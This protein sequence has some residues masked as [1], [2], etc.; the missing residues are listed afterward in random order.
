VQGIDAGLTFPRAG[1]SPGLIGHV[2]SPSGY[3][4]LAFDPSKDYL[5]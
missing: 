2:I 5:P 3:T 4:K 1:C